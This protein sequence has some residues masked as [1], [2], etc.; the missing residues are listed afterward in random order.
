MYK[1][2]TNTTRC[3]KRIEEG[4]IIGTQDI[5]YCIETCAAFHLTNA[6]NNGEGTCDEYKTTVWASTEHGVSP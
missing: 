4:G 2:T 3:P 6:M 1:T 5:G